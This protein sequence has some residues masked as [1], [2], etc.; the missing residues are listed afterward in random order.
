MSA[1]PGGT[2]LVPPPTEGRRFTS[3]RRVRLGD[4][5]PAGRLRLDALVRYAQDIA[6]DD[7][8]DADLRDADAWVVRRTVVEVSRFP[9]YDEELRLTT[10]CSGVGPRWADR[11]T[12]VVGADGGLVEM[13]TLW[14]AVDPASGRPRVLGPDFAARYGL[15]A[16]GRVV[17]ARLHHGRPAADAT[18]AAWPLRFTD[19]D[20]LG[21]V[22]NAA[23]WEPVEEVLATRRDLRAPLFAELEH[24]Q[25]AELGAAPSLLRHDGGD[26]SVALWLVSECDGAEAL[27]HASAVLRMA[28]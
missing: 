26:G 12:S 27:V 24:Q 18:G 5:S 10:W 9:V 1:V 3:S 19:F 28:S 22:N 21:H 20:V 4:A 23:Y 2:D 8:R 25:A 13:V 16:R 7:S 15:A 11:R 14:V 6:R 17:S